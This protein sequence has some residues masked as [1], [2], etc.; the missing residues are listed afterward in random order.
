MQNIN[1][2]SSRVFFSSRFK[3]VFLP[4]RLDFSLYIV[5]SLLLLTL[6]NVKRIWHYFNR[7]FPGNDGSGLSIS[8]KIPLLHSLS[9]A[10]QGRVLQVVFWIIVGIAIYILFWF[11]R[12]IT[13]NIRNDVVAGSYVRPKDYNVSNYWKPILVRKTLFGL[14]VVFLAAYIYAGIKM[15][16]ELG[17]LCYDYVTRFEAIHSTLYIIAAI[18][19]STIL[20]HI[21]IILCKVSARSWQFIY[22]DL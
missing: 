17:S 19:A 6:V 14:S 12:N 21:F 1:S 18:I 8:D 11:I 10:Y 16:M 13:N 4:S 15:I 22:T 2:N 7:Y 5:V 3:A 20:V 9:K